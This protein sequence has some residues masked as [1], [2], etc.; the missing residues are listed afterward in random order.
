MSRMISIDEI[1]GG[2]VQ[3]AFRMGDKYLMRG[4]VLSREQICRIPTQ[5]RN[6]LIDKGY[7]HVQLKGMET[8]EAGGE[9]FVMSLGFGRFDVIEGRKLNEAHLSREA[10]YALAR[11]PLPDKKTA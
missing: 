7:I 11:I 9:R 10:A 1:A 5:N 2:K 6:A 8:A 4:T 3:Q